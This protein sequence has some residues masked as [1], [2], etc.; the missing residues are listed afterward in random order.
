MPA[1]THAASSLFGSGFTND[2]TSASRATSSLALQAGDIVV[3][4]ASSEDQAFAFSAPTGTGLTFTERQQVNVSNYA[5]MVAWTAPVASTANVTITLAAPSGGTCWWG[6]IAKVYRDTDGVGTSAKQNNTSP[7]NLSVT[8]TEANSAIEVLVADW[9]AVDATTRTWR[10]VNSITPTA[11]NGYESVYTRNAA[12]G[13]VLSARYPD[14]GS[15]ASKSV[16]LSAPGSG[17]RQG[18][19]AVEIL[20]TAG[21]EERSTAGSLSLGIAAS[22]TVAKAAGASGTAALVVAAGDDAEKAGET[23]G[24]TTVMLA[25]TGAAEKQASAGGTAQ[26]ALEAAGAVEKAAATA[27]DPTLA[28]AASGTVDADSEERSTAGSVDIGLDATGGVEKAASTPGAVALSVAVTGDAPKAGVATG[29]VPLAAAASGAAS[30]SGAAAGAVSLALVTG[31]AVE[32]GVGSAGAV[33][34]A[35]AVSGTGAAMVPGGPTVDL[36]TARSASFVT[37]GATTAEFA[38]P[39]ATATPARAVT[40]ATFT[41]PAVTAQFEQA[42]TAVVV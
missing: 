11:G 4:L 15:V 42:E 27:G 20:G 29:A 14:A 36:E 8:T 18:T 12:A 3:V 19:I 25:G 38:A 22:G 10:T 24:D 5:R 34:L 31:G 2:G 7:P 30:K 21:G 37:A 40:T 41:R 32:K 35:L 39:E 26:F 13:T 16:G 23:A 6:G 9:N 1:P 33:A 28:L 17:W